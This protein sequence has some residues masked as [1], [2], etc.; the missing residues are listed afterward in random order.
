MTGRAARRKGRVA[1][2]AV[3][4][5]HQ[6]PRCVHVAGAPATGGCEGSRVVRH[7]S[8]PVARAASL[9]HCRCSSEPFRSQK[10]LGRGPHRRP[11]GPERRVR[12]ASLPAPTAPARRQGPR[13]VA[14][15]RRDRRPR[16]LC[17]L[18]VMTRDS[19]NGPDDGPLGSG[20]GHLLQAAGRYPHPRRPQPAARSRHPLTRPR[21][22]RGRR[23]PVAMKTWSRLRSVR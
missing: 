7:R 2:P 23:D 22:T 5:L 16:L 15:G 1:R 20:V 3:N 11:R 13:A 4:H 8:S 12:K 17:L 18:L 21:R 10:G 14:S 9:P 19:A 6:R